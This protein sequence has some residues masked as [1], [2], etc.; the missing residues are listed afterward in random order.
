M[1][2]PGFQKNFWTA[3]GYF[4][5]IDIFDELIIIQTWSLISYCINI[6]ESKRYQYIFLLS[7]SLGALISGYLII[8]Q[9]PGANQLIFFLMAALFLTASYA[10]ITYI[11]YGYRYRIS[12]SISATKESL[13]TLLASQK[14][15]KIIRYIV[16][17]VILIG[18]LNLLFKV[19]FD[20]QVNAHYEP[21]IASNAAAPIEA[22]KNKGITTYPQG[23][24]IDPKTT[25]IGHYKA[26][27]SAIQVF[28]QLLFGYFFARLWLNGKVLYA[29]PLLLIPNLLFILGIIVF[30]P[31]GNQT[32]V[33][34]GT[35]CAC[36]VNDLLRRVIFDSS[37]QLLMFSIPEKLCNAIRMY[38]IFSNITWSFCTV[39]VTMHRKKKPK[40]GFYNF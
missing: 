19:L 4:A 38:S 3:M 22:I 10:I 8:D 17:I 16:L 11:F 40:N 30:R 31:A 28:I 33:F 26:S 20:V 7:G 13:K 14:R 6:R 12:I 35:M 24:S 2:S 18:V 34:W 32:L 25:F 37:Y 29:Y 23:I 9:V 5:I 15:Y 21:N 27:I 36:A 39:G 1:I